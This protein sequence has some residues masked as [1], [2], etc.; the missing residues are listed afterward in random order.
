[1]NCSLRFRRWSS[2]RLVTVLAGLAVSDAQAQITTPINTGGFQYRYHGDTIWRQRDTTMVQTV[3][4]ADTVFRST[5]FHGRKSSSYTYLALGDSSRILESRDAAGRFVALV[6]RNGPSLA[7]LELDRT[8]IDATFR[9]AESETRMVEVDARMQEL[10]ERSA[11]LGMNPPPLPIRVPTI[12]V[13]PTSKLT[14]PFSANRLIEQLGDTVRYITGCAARPPVD[15]TVF[16]LF[17][18]DSV[19]RLRPSPR[20]FDKFMALAMHADMRTVLLRQRVQPRN[21]P[22]MKDVPKLTPWPCDRR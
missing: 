12:P 22:A 17:A 18:T 11:S 3:Y 7:S 21:V 1:M 2:T 9:M 15:T 13:S 5:F 4:R 14:Y 8:S 10:R 20:S 6:N 19:R 16:L